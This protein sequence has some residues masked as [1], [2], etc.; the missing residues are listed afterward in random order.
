L[1]GSPLLE[2][3][4]AGKLPSAVGVEDAAAPDPEPLRLDAE[5]GDVVPADRQGEVVPHIELRGPQRG[6]LRRERGS[7]DQRNGFRSGA[8]DLDLHDRLPDLWQPFGPVGSMG[9]SQLVVAADPA[10]GRVELEPGGPDPELLGHRCRRQV[11]R[12]ARQPRE[13]AF[14]GEAGID[15]G[16]STTRPLRQGE[17]QPGERVAD[18]VTVLHLGP[19]SGVESPAGHDVLE[20]ADIGRV[21]RQSYHRVHGLSHIGSGRA[22]RQPVELG[23]HEIMEPIAPDRATG[24]EPELEPV[25]R[26]PAGRFTLPGQGV[27]PGVPE[28]RALVV[29][30]AG[31]GHR[32]DHGTREVAV[33]DIER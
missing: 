5:S 23:R 13:I 14:A 29:V 28:H 33:A 9:Q 21:R 24:R 32:V 10:Q 31:P 1:I 17:V 19:G 12:S 8:G 4:Q 27:V 2:G 22:G 15:P 3:V 6:A 25:V 26:E 30:R 16:D 7:R 18:P 11:E 20:T